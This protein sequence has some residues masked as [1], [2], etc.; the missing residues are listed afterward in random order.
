MGVKRRNTAWMGLFL[1]LAFV[2]LSGCVTNTKVQIAL[3]RSSK[4]YIEWLKRYDSTLILIDL[5]SLTIPVALKTLKSCSGLLLTGGE[6]VYPGW[7][8]KESDTSGCTD[9]NRSRDSL[10][11]ALIAK[12]LEMKMPVF[13]ICRGH[14]ILNVY[15]GGKNII[16]IP[17]NF[18]TSV[19]HQCT[20]YLHCFHEVYI[21][22]Q[23]QLFM[24]SQCDS[25]E[26]TSNHHQGIDFL[27]TLLM[28]SATSG[29]K[30]IEAI[31]WANP[32]GK[33]FLMAV[34]WHP[35]RMEKTNPL[36]GPLASEFI[37]HI[38]RYSSHSTNK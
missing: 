22:P 8:G 5:D 25:A 34:Q 13:G 26:V 18:D 16:D 19:T 23:S 1:F 11:M 17:R 32:E 24:I 30:L 6:D 21:A 27:A 14:Q 3:S 9:M 33:S 12:A 31:E 20:D 38:H 36:S 4:N 7:Y 2:I 29:D 15:L 35:E 37:R 28:A 10:E